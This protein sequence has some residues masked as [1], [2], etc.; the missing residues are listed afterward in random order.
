MNVHHLVCLVCASTYRPDEVAYVCPR[1]GDDGVV[2]V[3]YDY[4]RIGASLA[5]ED[6]AGDDMWAYRPLLPIRPDSPTPKLRV[7]GTPLYNAPGL[8][9]RVGIA[10]VWVKDEGVEPT[11]SLKDRASAMAMVKAAERGA[12]VVTTSSTGNAGAA[13]AGVAASMGS[14]AIVFVP[15]TAPQAKVAQLLA[16]GAMVLLVEDGYDQAVELCLRAAEEFDWYN[17][18]T[19]YNPYMSEGKKTVAFE[20]ARQLDWR[21]PDVMSV[22]VG[23]GCII[24]SLWKGFHDLASLGWISGIPR[25]VGVQAAGSNYLAEAWEKGEDELTKPRIE[26][27][28][29]ADSIAAGLPRD[30]IKA[31]RAVRQSDGAFVTVSDEQILSAIP[32]LAAETGIFPE[33]AAAA[34]WAGMETARETGL[35]SPQDR[36][37]VLSTGNGLKDIP[38]AMRAVAATGARPHRIPAELDS[39]AAVLEKEKR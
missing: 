16:Y 17:R 35:I 24:G 7:G 33:P 30:R 13:L 9:D 11:G 21:V 4:E 23:D 19:G 15:A 36:V 8:A 1:H 37:V 38:A 28:T 27:V 14:S 32:I 29:L 39:V 10:D 31:M 20:I 25:L 6:P 2:D 5:K 3:V 34:S 26:A 22:P 12:A 18:T